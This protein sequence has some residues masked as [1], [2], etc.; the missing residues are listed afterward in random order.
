MAIKKIK[1]TSRALVPA[2][3]GLRKFSKTQMEDLKSII[4]DDAES[5]HQLVE[6]GKSDSAA[7]LIQKRLVQSLVDVMPYAENNVRESR[8]AKGVYAM[9]SL[10]T[11][12]R[13][14]LNDMQALRDKGEVGEA[15]VERVI[16]PAFM[17]LGRIMVE[18][19]RRFASEMQDYLTPKDYKVFREAQKESIKRVASEIN[20]M[21]DEAKTGARNYFQG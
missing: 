20:K 18:E 14:L 13:E 2:D 11:S 16:R 7:A 19:E 9:N 8:G 1:S 3:I 17:D 6:T 5:I 4:G 15:M 21:Y 10:V 12:L